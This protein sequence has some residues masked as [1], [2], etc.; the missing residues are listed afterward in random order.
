MAR[1]APELPATRAR[2]RQCACRRA[3]A[4]RVAAA[5]AGVVT[6]FAGACQHT[7]RFQNEGQPWPFEP[8]SLR[9]HPLTRFVANTDA[10][11]PTLETHLELRDQDGFDARGVG[12]LRLSLRADGRDAPPLLWTLDLDDLAANRRHFDHVTQTYIVPLAIDWPAVQPGSMVTL[13]VE[14][15][16]PSMTTMR[17]SARLAWP[18]MRANQWF[19]QGESAGTGGWPAIK[20][21]RSGMPHSDP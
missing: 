21:Q 9:I 18:M 17:A 6:L 11:P 13:S 3:L 7:G 15:E 14:L 4:R 16:R 10:G 8:T 19:N 20:D 12:L 1:S 5:V 2:D